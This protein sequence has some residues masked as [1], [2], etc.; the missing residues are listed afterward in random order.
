MIDFITLLRNNENWLINKILGYAETT[1]FTKYT[2]TLPEAW[3]LSISGLTDSLT[4]QYKTCNGAISAFHPE[5]KYESTHLTEFGITEAKKHRK[6]GIPLGMFLGLMKYY[7]MSY[8]DLIEQFT[9][10]S[11]KKMYLN[12]TN[13]CFDKIEITYCVEW[14]GLDRESLIEELQQSN[15]SITNEKNKFLTIFESV[16]LPLIFLDDSLNISDLNHAAIETFTDL[17]EAGSTYYNKNSQDHKLQNLKEQIIKVLEKNT[18]SAFETTLNTNNGELLFK[19]KVK[20]MQDVSKKYS[21]LVLILE[22]ITASRQAEISLRE[23]ELQYRNLANAGR[24]LIWTSGPDKKCNYFNNIWLNFTGRTLQ[25][26]LGDGWAA[27][28]HPDDFE[29]CLSTFISAFEKREQFEME[30]RMRHV[31]GDFRWI[32]DIGTPN[33]NIYGDFI[34]YIGHCFDITQ[35][36]NY[37]KALEVSQE[38]FRSIVESSPNAM[39]FYQLENDGKLI[40][41]GANPSSYDIMNVSQYDLIGKTIEEAF[42]GLATGIIEIYRKIASGVL[43]T[44]FYEIEYEDDHFSGIYHVDVYSTG[45][46][47]VVANFFDISDRKKQEQLLVESEEKYRTIFEE[48]LAGNFTLDKQ[49]II[50]DCNASFLRLLR[51][52]NKSQ[53]LGKSITGFYEDSSEFKYII[54]EL[55]KHRVIRDYES[56]IKSNDGELINIIENLVATFDSEGNIS[57]IQGNKYDITERKKAENA[58]KNSTAKYQKLFE[59][60]LTGN[61]ITDERGTVLDCNRSFLDIFGFESREE[62]VGKSILEF[63]ENLSE[64]VQLRNELQKNRLIRMY[65]TRRKRKDG[66]IIH[67]VENIVADFDS[68]GKISEIK[69]HL[70]DITKRKLLES[71]LKE[72]E[73]IARTLLNTSDKVIILIDSKDFSILDINEFGAFILDKKISELVGKKIFDFPPYSM[74]SNKAN[75]I[76]LVLSTGAPVDYQDEWDGRFFFN[77]I[78]PIINDNGAVGKIAIFSDDITELKKTEESLKQL[79]S[80]L[81]ESNRTK[82]KLFSVIAHDLRSPMASIVSFSEL[83]EKNISK[84]DKKTLS[85]YLKIITTTSENTLELLDNLLLWSRMKSGS[86]EFKPM[87]LELKTI[88]QEITDLLQPSASLKNIKL[89]HIATDDIV[90]ADANMLKTVIRNLLQNAVKFTNPGGSVTIRHTLTNNHAEVT[91]SDNGVGMNMEKLNRLFQTGENISTRGTLDEKGSGLGL[92]LC[93]EFIERHGGIIMVQSTEGIGSE[94][95]FTLPIM[96]PIHDDISRLN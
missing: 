5:D 32:L 54:G 6:R 1:G 11:E 71:S 51:Y 47:A 83:I 26:E 75:K 92:I 52:E 95:K 17:K 72:S 63:Y 3:R 68:D 49:G 31:S 45:P 22:D 74:E 21:G 89:H 88:I 30:Y 4:S 70:F 35:R 2:S 57:K 59:E 34:G 24:A 56:I 93:K 37:E 28:V 81:S 10:N 77:Q 64:D 55:Q 82:D 20:K 48:G 39:H 58:F 25:E 14:S 9:A 43:K 62:I 73:A 94:F 84:Y 13:N 87:N 23:K 19:V 69:C 41:T 44:H 60:D 36:K 90:F 7:R 40:F 29:F 27:N 79:N 53:I 16:Q 67:V 15:R 42:P 8:L 38:K 50:L 65:E 85:D 96:N 66:K 12:F 33:Y 78:Y 86:F 80:K 18:G 91:V 76:E 46:G 61:F